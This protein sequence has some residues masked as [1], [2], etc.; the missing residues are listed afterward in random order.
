MYGDDGAPEIGHAAVRLPD[1][2]RAWG[3]VTDRDA[4]SAMTREEFCGRAARL[5]RDGALLF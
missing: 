2:R 5:T 1:G 3:N 4:A